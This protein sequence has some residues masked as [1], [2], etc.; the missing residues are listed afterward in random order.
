VPVRFASSLSGSWYYSRARVLCHIHQPAL[1]GRNID[2]RRSQYLFSSK[3]VQ[4]ILKNNKDT[5]I[6]HEYSCRAYLQYRTCENV[7]TFERTDIAGA[8]KKDPR[9]RCSFS[10]VRPRTLGMHLALE[11]VGSTRAETPWYTVVTIRKTRGGCLS[12]LPKI[13]VRRTAR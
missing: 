6:V 1:G 2:F 5:K 3:M 12:L 7:A 8:V 13:E 9:L 11:V 4:G 10:A